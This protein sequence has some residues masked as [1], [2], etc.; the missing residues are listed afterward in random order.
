MADKKDSKVVKEA[1]PKSKEKSKPAPKKESKPKVVK[2]KAVPKKEEKPKIVAKPKSKEKKSEPK[3]ISPK[4]NPFSANISGMKMFGRW[5]SQGIQVEDPGM[6]RYINLEP[7]LVPNSLGRFTEK[8]FWKSKRPIVER[9]MIRLFVT[10]HRGKKHVRTS[11]GHSGVKVNAY[12]SVI[13]AFELVE[14]KTKRN[15]I[16]VLVR[17]IEAA[18]PREGITTIEYGGVRYPK[19]VDLSPQRRIDLALRWLTQGAFASAVSSKGRK[20]LDV[21]LA[22]QIVET[23]NRNQ[24]GSFAYQK[25]FEIER[26]AQ[27]AR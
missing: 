23:M 5:S 13:K 22:E 8:Q 6:K 20:K 2:K 7:V 11:R 27:A 21:A 3:K 17:A 16:E 25:R 19:A 1:V 26:Q 4:Q 18:G 24:Q 12:N 14:Q 15:P 9:L 10:G